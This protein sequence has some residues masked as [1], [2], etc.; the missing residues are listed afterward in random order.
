MTLCPCCTGKEFAECCETIINGSRTAMTAEELMRAR[1]SAH[2]KVAVDF[3]FHST[4]PDHRTNYD[5]KGTKSWAEKSQ[6]LG[7]EVITTHAG[8]A[9][10]DRGE[11]EFIARFRDKG[12]I[13]NHHE[14]GHF[15][16]VD[17]HW[18]FTEGEMVK[19]PPVTTSKVGRN[20]PCHCG[21]GKKFKKCCGQ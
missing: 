21:S 18:L 15:A 20:D 7:L 14:R 10:D 2:D 13:R 5:H 19:S 9:T 6:W 1:Y 4:H 16:K 12:V 11:V 8:T 17:G 3:L